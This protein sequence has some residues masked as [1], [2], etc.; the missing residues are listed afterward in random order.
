MNS[1]KK[2]KFFS[3]SIN[4]LLLAML[5][6]LLWGSA[7]PGVKI[8]YKL[9]NIESGNI[10]SQMLFAGVR[11]TL[12]GIVTIIV[13]CLINQ[14]V[15]L[16]TKNNIKGISILG[17]IQTTIQ[18]IFYYIG[19]AH[20]TGVK[21]AIINSI[22]PFIVIIIC[23]IITTDDKL[24]AQKILGCILG[25][26]GVVTINLG[27]GNTGE[28]FSLVGEGFIIISASSFA[29]GS[30]YSKR[31][32]KNE[33][34]IMITGYQLLIGGIILVLVS[35]LNGTPNIAINIKALVLLLYL[36]FLSSVAFTIWTM[37]LKYNNA[38]KVSIYNFLTPIFG[39]ILSGIFLGESIFNL[40]SLFALLLVSSGIFVINKR[41]K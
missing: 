30:I 20:T 7:F 39:T 32:T 9:F 25:F 31:I 10:Y 13:C 4:L 29:I 11:F 22:A 33:D 27:G 37:L 41:K 15:V 36:S 8:G 38:G 26:L 3:S 18:Y 2:E 17:V 19:M 23:H 34:P 6:T 24:N 40:K 21:G 12:S 35:F 14:K 28:T 5:C 16:P 1:N